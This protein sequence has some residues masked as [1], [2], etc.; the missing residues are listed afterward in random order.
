MAGTATRYWN[1]YVERLPKDELHRLREQ[2]LLAQLEHVIAHN[3]FYRELYRE[4]G[5]T[6]GSVQSLEEFRER[7]PFIDK[8]ALLRDQEATPPYGSRLARPVEELAII[9]LTSGTSGRGREVHCWSFEDLEWSAR[10]FCYLCR[11]QGIDPGDRFFHLTRVS[12]EVGGIWYKRGSEKYGLTYLN[13]SPYD[14]GTRLEYME[15]F[16]PHVVKTS[17][18]YLNRLTAECRDRDI[19]PR[20]AFPDLKVISIGTEPHIPD[21]AAAMEEWWGVKLHERFGS[22]Q[23]GGTHLFTCEA[24]V[25]TD[26]KRGMMHN[27]D[28]LLYMEV[29]DPETGEHV[30]SGEEGELVVTNLYITT[31]PSIRFRMSDRVRF[32]ANDECGCGRPFDGIECG[33]VARFDDMI[34]IKA[35]NVW[36]DT[37]DAVVLNAPGV[38][39]Y[40][41]R[42][43]I[44]ERGRETV[45]LR[46]EFERSCSSS[47]EERAKLFEQLQGELKI[48]TGVTMELVEA[49]PGSVPTFEVKSRRWKDERLSA[50]VPT[51]A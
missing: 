13:A 9:V 49:E 34:K 43:F 36:P 29:I 45:E 35:Y 25:Q 5:I 10:Q 38:S 2:R 40:A 42:V 30:E 27:M 7:V 16:S 11:W 39:E 26:G 32:M 1:R 19:D 21:W 15:K 23:S 14:T 4:H 22:T 31:S 37:V 47:Q 18:A 24:G 48:Q 8:A 50:P 46:V 44:N 3:P 51:V 28:H 17:C 20:K 12:M 6:S 33:S 41:A